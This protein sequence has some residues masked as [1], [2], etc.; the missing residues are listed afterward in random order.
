M[1]TD[2]ELA[3][4]CQVP[5]ARLSGIGCLQPPSPPTT[6]AHVGTAQLTKPRSSK[7]PS[8]E[9]ASTE[10]AASQQLHRQHAH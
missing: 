1:A 6:I 9:H 2:A 5:G 4:L 3:P 8:T 7:H 10:P